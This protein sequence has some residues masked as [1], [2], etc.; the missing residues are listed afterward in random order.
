[1]IFVRI[2]AMPCVN[3]CWHCF[4]S[5]SPKDPSM[6]GET[7]LGILDDLALLK[8]ESG[9]TVFPLF[10]DEP[11]I[12]PDF[13][14]I[15]GHQ[16]ALGL[17]FD[18][19]W[20]PTN[21]YGLVRLSDEGWRELAGKGFTGI[22]LTFHGVGE[23]HDR[24]A[25]RVGAYDDLV[26]TIRRAECFGVDWFAGMMLNAENASEYEETKA[27]VETLGS[28]CTRFGWMLPMSQGRA[29]GTGN[30]VRLGQVSHLIG[31]DSGWRTEAD[32]VRTILA[33]EAL[34]GRRAWNPDCGTISLDVDHDLT[35]TFG[36]GCDGDPYDCL[37]AAM[38]LGN[39]RTDSMGQC[40]RRCMEEPPTPAR[41]LSGMT[42]GG[43][44][45]RYGDPHSD[46]V[47]HASDLAGRKWASQYLRD[48]FQG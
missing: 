47:Y 4:C 8:K 10:Y 1:M 18:D 9:E 38:V 24:R 16:L 23:R 31:P 20:F 30:R 17:I 7:V 36:G 2:H 13:V 5:G 39:L 35:V 42:W 34:S 41:M 21:G 19:W 25:G 27:E 33:D 22:R 28:P 11:T 3:R 15:L 6:D 43:L 46:Y 29:A 14:S 26:E 45:T 40:Y 32:H 48:S 12:H 44:A 37:K